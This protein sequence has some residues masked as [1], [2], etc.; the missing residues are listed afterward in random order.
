MVFSHLSA[1]LEQQFASK[2][3]FSVA[4]ASCPVALC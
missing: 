1:G 3:L 4:P 2:R